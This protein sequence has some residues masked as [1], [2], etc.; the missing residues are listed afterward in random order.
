MKID[1]CMMSDNSE[2]SEFRKKM[3]K[4]TLYG[5][6][7]VEMLM[8]IAGIITQGTY[9]VYII[10]L[11]SIT[12]L[13]II[14]TKMNYFDLSSSIFLISINCAFIFRYLIIESAYGYL[15]TIVV[16]IAASILLP[17]KAIHLFFSID[18]IFLIIGL[19]MGSF[20][21]TDSH[22][23]NTG[24]LYANS[25]TACLP[26]LIIFY[27]FALMISN[28][29]I[30]TI[31]EL[32][33]KNNEL[34]ETQNQL[35]QQEKIKSIQILAGGIAHDFNNILTAVLGNIDLLKISGKLDEEN[36]MYVDDALDALK[37]ARNLTNQL[38][39]FSK[40][41][42]I[43]KES[44][45][46]N[47]L[48]KETAI[49]TLRGKKSQLICDL[50]PN[51]W[52]SY[53]DK[54]QISQVIQNI[55]MNADQAM[56]NTGKI[57]ITSHNLTIPP[58]HVTNLSPNNYI[59]ISIADT[60]KGIIHDAY[61]K[62]FNPFYTTKQ[63]GSGLGLA[64]SYNIVKNHGGTIVFESEVNVGTKFDIYLPAEFEK[65][66]DIIQKNNPLGIW[67]A[68]VL[69]MDD[70]EGVIKTLQRYLKHLGFHVDIT[71][72]GE[73]AIAL[74]KSHYTTDKTYGLVILDLTVPGGMG[75]D[76]ALLKIQEINPQVKAI[77]SSGYSKES[78]YEVFQDKP[79]ILMLKKPYTIEELSETLSK[80]ELDSK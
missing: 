38:L 43:V 27:I 41:T 3:L 46:I 77:I 79:N 53:G 58:N 33:K 6:L 64:L 12:L 50:E 32:Q 13:A 15:F 34:K 9:I 21:F 25:V 70:D 39:S 17:Q 44:L 22:D 4:V 5:S 23:P 76:I 56:E 63:S 1:K 71:T 48:L 69:V 49:F 67:S 62:I 11:T 65:V 54:I 8:M 55:T 72:N 18:M 10:L 75:G 40:P 36:Q 7:G 61:D 59:K 26:I 16:L 66:Q 2:F 78:L 60:G 35:V 19:S 57:T 29:F 37:N 45:D 24:L 42:P 31:S 14:L 68:S 52:R 28:I 74:Y 80:L 73:D 47:K 30:R 20:V 51:L